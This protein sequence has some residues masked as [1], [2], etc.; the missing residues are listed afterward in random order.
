VGFAFESEG[1]LAWM[2][3]FDRFMITG[4]LWLTAL[5]CWGRVQLRQALQHKAVE[6][7]ARGEELGTS[8]AALQQ[9]ASVL[10][11]DLR[12][13][14]S[15]IG[16]NAELL[17]LGIDQLDESQIQALGAIRHGIQDMKQMMDTILQSS[18]AQ[19]S[20]SRALATEA[21][22]E[23]ILTD[24]LDRLNASVVESHA[25]I[26]HDPLPRVIGDRTQ[27]SRVFQNLIQNAI[28]YRGCSPPEIFISADENHKEWTVTIRDNGIGIAPEQSSKIFD[29]F[30]RGW[31][32]EK[33]FEG[34]G[35][36]LAV[37]K[38]IIDRHGGRIWI[39][40]K[41]GEGTAVMFTLSK[42]RA[43]P[44]LRGSANEIRCTATT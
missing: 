21:D 34:S 5:L 30:Q 36:G 16:L 24:A 7:E 12:A 28:K 38:Q 8:N 26:R 40:S 14:L 23:Q 25:T 13:P 11:H 17:V 35:I 4:V 18:R 20:Q 1:A 22:C 19:H 42:P 10:S 37:C 6:L 32:D 39:E 15:S 3:A 31:S 44:V 2:S 9:F 41:V 33:R 43:A 29:M 27:L